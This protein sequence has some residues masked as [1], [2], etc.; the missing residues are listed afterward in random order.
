[1]WLT[2][3]LNYGHFRSRKCWCLKYRQEPFFR[4]REKKNCQMRHWRRPARS[5]G[6]RF[7]Q[8]WVL[9]FRQVSLYVGLINVGFYFV[10]HFS[11]SK[12]K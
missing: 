11:I 2:S 1:V 8:E 3:Q 9:A 6:F 12:D 10:I 4:G 5:L 7:I